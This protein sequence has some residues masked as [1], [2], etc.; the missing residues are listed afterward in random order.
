MARVPR[1]VSGREAVRAFERAGFAFVR[2]T[3]KNHYVLVRGD[4]VLTVPEG[5]LT[6]ENAE[7]AAKGLRE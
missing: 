6:A 5:R 7:T 3:K 4:T 2:R 1:N